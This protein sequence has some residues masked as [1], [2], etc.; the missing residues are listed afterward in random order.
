MSNKSSV[1]I[2]IIKQIPDFFKIVVGYCLSFLIKNRCWLILERGTDAQDNA[3]HFYKYL[4]NSHKNISV[5]YAIKKC[6]IDYENNLKG[7]QENTIN[8]GSILYYAYLFKASKIISTHINTDMPGWL[9]GKLQNTCLFPRGKVVFLQHGIIHNDHKVLHYPSVKVDLFI[10]GAKREFELISKLYGYPK[11]IVQYTGLAR[12]DN[13]LNCDPRNRILIMPTWRMSY[14][15]L[16]DEQF[17]R[18]SFFKNYSTILSDADIKKKLHEKNYHLDFYNHFEFQKFNHLFK[19]FEDSNVH[20][21]EFG[22]KRVQ[23]LLKDANLLITDYSSI[24]YDFIYMKKPVVFFL[25]DQ[26]EFRSQQYGDDFDNPADFGDVA[27]NENDLKQIILAAL[28]NDCLMEDKY[29]QF[30]QEVFPL[31]DTHNCERIFNCIS[32][33]NK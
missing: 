11:G 12:F 5:K 17:V 31:N 30:A 21:L 1:L 13:L 22:H 2:Y 8:Y 15:N 10:A 27:L 4:R 7:Y 28:D 32:N 29:R 18:T 33:L 24:Y 23:E 3:W 14:K 16:K 6:S 26:E 9:K 25:P 19:E 20:I